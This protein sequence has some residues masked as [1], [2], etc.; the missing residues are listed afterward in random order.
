MT[1]SH[2]LPVVDGRQPGGS[3]GDVQRFLHILWSPGDVRELRIPRHNRYGHTASGY[4]DSPDE[5][6]AAAAGWDGRANLYVSLNPVS[7]ALLARANS[8]IAARA[9]ATTAD[10]DVTRRRS[11]LLD[12]DPVRPSG[13]SS[14]DSELEAAHVV[15][16]SVTAFLSDEGWPD[17]M[18]ALSGNGYYA[19]YAINLPNDQASLE[20]AKRVLSGLAARFDTDRV[21]VDT[22]VANAARLVGLIGTLKV[23]GD[24]TPDRPHRRSRLESVPEA[25]IPVS[26]EL[27]AALAS[28]VP[29]DSI[30]QHSAGA[31]SEGSPV[32]LAALLQQHGIEYREQAPDANGFTWYHVRQ[33]PFHADG[34]QFECGVGQKLPDGPF[35]G[36][37]FHPE[38]DRMGWQEWKTALG[39]DGNR[40]GESSLL[41]SNGA[42]SQRERAFPRTDAGNGELFAQCHGDHVRYD[43][44]RKRWLIWSGHWW[45]PDADEEVRRLAKGTARER[46]SSAAD[47]FEDLDE[48][49]RESTFAIGSENRQRLDAML[50]QAQAEAPISDAGDNWDADRWL[51]G[52]ANGVVDLRTCEPRDGLR[53]DR[54]T[55]HS[56]VPL[57]PEARCPRWERFLE[58]VFG[59]DR[60]LIGFIARAVGYSLT[61]D[62]SEQCLFM[63]HGSGANGKSVF[64]TTLRAMAGGYA[65]NSPFS[66]FELADRSSIPNDLAALVGRRLVTASETNE[67]VRL[68]EARLKAL[69]GGDPVTARFLHGEFFTFQPV[70]KLWLAVNHRPRVGDDSYGFWRR[71]RLIPFTRR[72][73][74][75]AD[76]HL[77]EALRTELPGIL[78][79]AVRGSLTWQEE[80]LEPPKAVQS[81]TESYRVE[82]DPLAE[83]IEE[84]CAVGSCFVASGGQLYEAY[85]QWASEQGM[86]DREVL[87]TV[88]FGRR[89]SE[90][91]EKRHTKAGKSYHGVGLLSDRS[92]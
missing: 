91:F 73:T 3:L 33:C 82:S 41:S 44:R 24:S 76:H 48:R 80:G 68:N 62:V 87:S 17:P 18:T 49:K 34:R 32:R 88:A 89:M 81:A 15:L 40:L 83:F 71:V 77:A 61:G 27:L 11:L 1:T 75:N 53:E 28:T 6:A 58:E 19:I 36:K 20:L 13:I 47:L 9:E 52:V 25:L 46:Y 67:A 84:R 23:K 79:W 22:A 31:K 66:T 7:P 72:F 43:H 55:L 60:E 21:H 26:G 42:S 39:I 56:D 37:C 35:A 65:Y 57:D 16:D 59:E 70:C 85:R 29:K 69:T 45:R 54:I 92:A 64:L 14:T 90:R 10:D 86:R 78:N 50:A 2:G 12:I 30:R 5:L 4:F 38:G 74:D 51:L 8:R 63:C